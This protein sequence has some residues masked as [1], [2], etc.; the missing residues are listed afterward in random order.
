RAIVESGSFAPTQQSLAA[1]E[2]FGQAFATSAGCPDQSA[3]CLRN[4]SV[5]NLVDNFP[6][7]AIPGIVDG[8]VIQESV[9]QAL[10]AGRFTHVPVLNGINHDEQRIFVT[11]LNV[12]VTGGFFVPIL[13]PPIT[14]DNYQAVIAQVLGVS[15]ARAAAIATEYPVGSYPSPAAAFSTLDADA[16][17]ACT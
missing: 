14:T 9:G 8:A 3:A 12:I 16:W 2:A 1:G 15:A 4:L 6:G 13:N 11:F 10:A 7:A 5:S 17:W